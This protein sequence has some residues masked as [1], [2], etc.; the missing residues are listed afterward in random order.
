[1]PQPP[2]ENAVGHTV[3]ELET[4]PLRIAMLGH[5]GIPALHGG[6]ERHVDEIAR[7]LV[8]LGHRV[9][10]F[11]R[12]YH[13]QPSGQYEGV[14]VLRRPSLPTKHF[15]A[16][17]HTALCV[18]E[19]ILTRRYDLLHVHGIG[20]GIFVGWARPFV[21]TVF[22][23]HALDWRQQKWGRL[24]RW[25][26]QR[27]ERVAVRRAHAVIT[28]SKLL[29]RYVHD[30]HGRQAQY[31]PNGATL[32]PRPA[33][34]RLQRWGLTPGGYLLFVGRLI[35]DRGLS[36]LLDAWSGIADER[37]LVIVGDVQH[38][39]MHVEAL[40]RQA[41]SR[42]VFT[43]Y[44]SGAALDQLYAHAYLCV[45][46]S[47]VE[48]LPIA[49]LEAMS[50]GRAVLVSDIPE[51]L[52]AIGDAG[53]SFAVRDG[54]DLR[55]RLEALLRSPEQVQALGKRARERVREHYDWD[56]IALGTEAVYR[57]ALR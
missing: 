30:V 55:S 53:A 54:R 21:R 45:H 46:P 43:G 51:N 33:S 20:P 19:T 12:P 49:V 42:V 57:A 28:V 27:G 41:D 17:T 38:D 40:R 31:I 10:V 50:H 9:D 48:G 56:R 18:L 6:I 47:E 22:T 35:S 15:D 26:L 8:R 24:A 39:R 52:E 34:D 14:R 29:E 1:V 36:H 32:R 11:N 37:R 3:L 7:R 44:Q 23:F 25:S 13:P 16:G 5:K 4:R 2:A